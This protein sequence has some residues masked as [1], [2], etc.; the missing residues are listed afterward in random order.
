LA[1]AGAFPGVSARLRQTAARFGRFNLVGLAGF[2]VQ[3]G[4]L[5]ALT[6]WTAWPLPVSV[7]VAVLVTVT[8]NF[9]WH[10]RYTWPGATDRWAVRWLAFAGSNGLISLVTNLVVTTALAGAGVP[11]LAANVVA[12]GA[13]ALVNFL[14]SDRLVFAR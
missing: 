7:A 8:H 5:H 2:V 3:L 10:V 12:V 4:L 6:R 13:A 14:V 11:V 9:A 1:S